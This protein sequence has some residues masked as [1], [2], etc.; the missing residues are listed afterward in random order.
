MQNGTGSLVFI[1]SSGQQISFSPTV[2]AVP[3]GTS[4]FTYLFFVNDT[5]TNSYT[6]TQEQLTPW[7]VYPSNTNTALQLS[8]PLSTANLVVSK[9]SNQ[10]FTFIWAI[11]LN[12]SSG[13]STNGAIGL[14]YPGALNLIT[15]HGNYICGGT[16]LE[17][18]SGSTTYFSKGAGY[19]YININGVLYAVAIAT[20]VSSNSY[21][22]SS[23]SAPYWGYYYS[24]NVHSCAPGSEFFLTV[25]TPPNPP[26]SKPSY[27]AMSWYNAFYL[28]T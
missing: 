1:E 23:L 24:G 15:Y 8:V 26:G 5:S 21:T 17:A 22:P 20:D 9:S 6:T 16:N 25:T 11:Q 28:S 14:L 4:S 10:I 18:F 3:N 7:A 27:A 13:I 19:Y 2:L 12:F